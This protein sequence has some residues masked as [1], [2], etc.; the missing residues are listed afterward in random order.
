MRASVRRVLIVMP[1]VLVVS[2]IAGRMF[3]SIRDDLAGQR[4]AIASGWSAVDQALQQR[5]GLIASLTAVAQ[6]FAAV[7]PDLLK[8]I[9]D[10]H[11]IVTSGPAPQEKVRA[12]DRLSLALARLLVAAENYPR[13]R[14]NPGFLRSQDEIKS[15]EDRIAMAR[16]KYND[17]LEH[18][19]ARIQSFPYNLVARVSGFG[20]NDEYFPT[21]HF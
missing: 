10:A 7:Q 20:R 12:N 19:N 18:Y 2:A 17:S 6:R 9:A 16:R 11:A 14:S 21:E 1:V 3:F 8:E 5:A 13:L 4:D 15:S